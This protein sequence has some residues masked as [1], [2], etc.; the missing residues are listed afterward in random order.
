MELNGAEE[1][2]V[3]WLTRPPTLK[4][5]RYGL[6]QLEPLVPLSPTLSILSF[7]SSPKSQRDPPDYSLASLGIIINEDTFVHVLWYYY[8]QKGSLYLNFLSNT[9]SLVSLVSSLFVFFAVGHCF[10]QFINKIIADSA[11]QFRLR[12]R[13]SLFWQP[14]LFFSLHVQFCPRGGWS[15]L[16]INLLIFFVTF[17]SY[18][19]CRNHRRNPNP[20]R[21]VS[22][23]SFF[24]ILERLSVLYYLSC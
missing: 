19:K 14:L 12:M 6:Q 3:Q 11:K 16:L 20:T 17:N 8:G 5:N 21:W 13:S 18:S 1:S 2:S 10:E 15:R 22:T 24:S 23:L 9:V 4:S 7:F